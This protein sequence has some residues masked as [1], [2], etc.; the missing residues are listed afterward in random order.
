M[1]SISEQFKVVP[2]FMEPNSDLIN[3][4]PTSDWVRCDY[5]MLIL[6]PQ[7]VGATGTA[8]ITINNA[9]DN[10]GAGSAA[11][12]FRYRLMTTAGGLDTWGAFVAAAA[13]GYAQVASSSK[14]TLIE[15]RRDELDSAKPFV[16]MTLTELV[17]GAVIA[18]AVAFVDTGRQGEQIPSVL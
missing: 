5:G 14:A 2:L 17:D 15:V 8:T 4:S 18:G 9:S 11:I 6:L 13:A 10:A 1:N 7:G 3:G 12:A 16:S